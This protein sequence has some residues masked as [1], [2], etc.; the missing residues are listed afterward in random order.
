MEELK[1]KCISSDVWRESGGYIVKGPFAK[2]PTDVTIEQTEYNEDTGE[3]TLKVKPLRGDRVYYNISEE[4]TQASSE[5]V[6][7][8]LT[9]RE[10]MAYFLCVDSSD[11]DNPHPTGK[12]KKWIG[13]VKLKYEQRQNTNG[14]Q[15]LELETHRD[16]EIRY[17]TDGSNPKEYGII[18][19]GDI[20]LPADC[21]CVCVAIY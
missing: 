18:Y 13:E 21:R 10:P 6:N 12:A 7:Q 17:T 20:V 11:R 15:I 3:F 16:F 8:T 14:N 4:P 1:K 19:S 9:L 2:E 5:V